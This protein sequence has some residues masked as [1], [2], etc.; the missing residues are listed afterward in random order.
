MKLHQALGTSADRKLYQHSDKLV[1]NTDGIGVEVELENIT[2]LDRDPTQDGYPD[3]TQF[4]RTVHDGSLRDG[5]EFIFVDALQGDNII[6]ALSI[7]Q[8]FIDVYRRYGEPVR[9]NE[10]CSVHVHLDVRDLD[11]ATLNN[12]ILIYM[13]IERVIFQYI[14]PARSKNNYCRPLTDST[15]KHTLSNILASNR[16]DFMPSLVNI[17]K[18]E[19]DKYSALNVLPIAKY[20]SV[21]FRH[22]HGTTDTSSILNWI[23]IILSIK[24]IARE[25]KASELIDYSISHGPFETVKLI[26]KGSVL[27]DYSVLSNIIDF[28]DLFDKGVNDVNEIVNMN[29]LSNPS[30]RKS[31]G[32]FLLN[33]F[34]EA[35]GIAVEPKV[36]KGV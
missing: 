2:Y 9:V 20:G 35:N 26:C 30:V 24:N 16:P 28:E 33:R 36:K 27:D 5:T 22:H 19:C 31:S 29:S 15:F 6:Q 13:L 17:V 1:S 23:N 11:E 21:E 4:W 34:K 14:N 25:K 7:F 8:E 3:F 18:R 32:E 12:L 10:R